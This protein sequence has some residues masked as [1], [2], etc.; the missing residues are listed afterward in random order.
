MVSKW[1]ASP[2]SEESE[3]PTEGDYE[4]MCD[5]LLA[6]SETI[7]QGIPLNSAN[8]AFLASA[9]RDISEGADPKAAFRFPKRKRGEKDTREAVSKAVRRACKVAFLLQEKRNKNKK[10]SVE[11]AIGEIAADEQAP[12]ETIK[13]AWRDY[14][15]YIELSDSGWAFVFHK[16]MK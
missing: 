7:S 14:G 9:L 10:F 6:L 8:T 5:Y 11:E 15:K 1:L 3:P 4:A 12:E 2:L 13:A 16:K